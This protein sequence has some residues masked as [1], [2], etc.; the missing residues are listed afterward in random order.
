VKSK[1][2]YLI[3]FFAATSLTLASEKSP[4][5]PVE[6]PTPAVSPTL[7]ESEKVL[8]P[9]VERLQSFETKTNSLSIRLE[10][11]QT[12]LE[13]KTQALFSHLEEIQARLERIKAEVPP[14][15]TDRLDSTLTKSPVTHDHE[16][17]FDQGD[18][19]ETFQKG[20][21]FFK[22]E[23]FS[24]AILTLSEFVEKNKNH[25]LAGPAQFYVGES[26]FKQKEYQL[27]IQ[28]YKQVI[29]TYPQST[30]ISDAISQ[31]AAAEEANKNLQDSNHYREILNST[32]PQS[33]AAAAKPTPIEKQT[34]KDTDSFAASHSGSFVTLDPK[35]PTAPEADLNSN[36][37]SPGTGADKTPESL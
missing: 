31:L 1:F 14:P 2:Y 5:P 8:V 25:I 33:P 18:E 12:R 37:K 9:L 23:K 26:Y 10:E 32:F 19:T 36:A 4:I 7:S 24:E 21:M 15:L 11:I 27:A 34:P 20:L 16:T 29:Q 3:S 35:P 30:H 17:H 22:T 13:Q 6:T 28:E